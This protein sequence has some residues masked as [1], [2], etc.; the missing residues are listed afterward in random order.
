[1]FFRVQPI[2]LL[3]LFQQIIQPVNSAEAAGSAQNGR[4]I[5]FEGQRKSDEPLTANVGAAG[6]PV[7]ATAL[8]CAGCHGRDGQGRPEGGVRPT[9]I[10]WLNLSREYGGSAALGRRYNAYDEDSFLRAVTSGIDSA[11]N[12]LD[13]SMPRYNLSRRDARDLIAY[14]EVIDRDLD[15]GVSPDA[16]V[17]GSLQPSVGSHARLGKAMAEVLRARFDDINREGGIYG[18]SLE[19]VVEGFDDRQSFVAAADAMLRK[20]QVFALANVYSSTADERLSAMVEDEGIPSIA[21]YTQF[22]AAGDG[23][24][25]SSFYI[26]GGLDAQVSALVRR[27]AQQAPGARAYV[28]YRSSGAFGTV[29]DSARER[30]AE[31][32]FAD[33]R[34]IGYSADQRLADLIGAAPGTDSLVLFLGTS[35]D[36]VGLLDSSPNTAPARLYLPGYFVG[37]D[38]LKLAPAQAARLEMVYPTVP[39][40]VADETLDNFLAFLRKNGLPADLLNTRLYAYAAGEILIEGLKRAG[41][42]LT[43]KK[44][45]EAMETL[46][47]FDAGLSKP[48]SYGSRRRVGLRGAYIVSLDIENRAL[49]SS[50]DWV[51]LD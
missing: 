13:S 18:R 51:D 31:A 22:P 39:G 12:T 32:G 29:A 23:R 2:V 35:A 41:K 9:N 19:L 27:C 43:R 30:L 45:I 8:P 21:P 15:P 17:I 38:I 4:L 46:Y 6:I 26:H 48:V 34:V 42:R 1:M 7:P 36:L 40:S 25:Q 49:F 44:L 24:Y 14:L 3:A 37:S 10:T 47:G 11:G 20:Q 5:F 33:A 28:M 50:G 16:I